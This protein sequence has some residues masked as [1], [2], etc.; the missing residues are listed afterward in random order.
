MER[1]LLEWRVAVADFQ[2]YLAQRKLGRA[3]DEMVRKYRPDQ[4]RAPKGTPEG[5]QWVIDPIGAR[6]RRLAGER[7]LVAQASASG[8]TISPEKMFHIINSHG[9]YTP[10]TRS[11]NS[12]FLPQY[13]NPDA[14]LGIANE[15][16]RRKIV[17]NPCRF[18]N[19]YDM[20]GDFYDVDT[21]TGLVTPH[22]VG[23]DDNNQLTHAVLIRFDPIT[24]AVETMFPVAS[25]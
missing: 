10:R 4:P 6:Q 14:I 15:L 8:F 3:I 2:L 7:I 11:G 25:R 5:G 23:L 12:K 22:F 20:V 21:Q 19:L 24:G 1:A 17:P 16:F 9:F 13:S 18:G